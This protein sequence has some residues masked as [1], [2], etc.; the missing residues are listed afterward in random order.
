MRPV[1]LV[2]VAG[3]MSFFE[4]S[5]RVYLKFPERQIWVEIQ[6]KRIDYSQLLQCKDTP[7]LQ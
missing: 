5:D 1:F 2:R 6:L 7:T 4:M 3:W